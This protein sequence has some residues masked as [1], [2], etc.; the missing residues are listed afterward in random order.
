MAQQRFQ[1]TAPGDLLRVEMI[2]GPGGQS[3]GIWGE[4][5]RVRP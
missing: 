1:R 3:Y 5:R 2:T 4:K